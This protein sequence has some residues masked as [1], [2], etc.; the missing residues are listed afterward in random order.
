MRMEEGEDK[1]QQQEQEVLT[2]RAVHRRA[3]APRRHRGLL[4]PLER[5]QRDAMQVHTG[6]RQGCIIYS[7]AQR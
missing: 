3:A 7:V 4:F 2:L 1:E 6:I 5:N